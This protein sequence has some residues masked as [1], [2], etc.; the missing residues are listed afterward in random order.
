MHGQNPALHT[1]LCHVSKSSVT[2]SS[3]VTH[4]FSQPH[5]QPHRSCLPSTPPGPPRLLPPPAEPTGSSF[6]VA[7]AARQLG[8]REQLQWLSCRASAER[9]RCWE[10]PKPSNVTT[11]TSQASS[12]GIHHDLISTCGWPMVKAQSE[13]MAAADLVATY[14]ELSRGTSLR[15]DEYSHARCVCSC[16]C[17]CWSNTFGLF[18]DYVYANILLWMFYSSLKITIVALIRSYLS[19][20][21]PS[22]RKLDILFISCI[23]IL[24]SI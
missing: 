23:G 17:W 2:Y 14:G 5:C 11:A 9:A 8:L 19:T 6:S 7:A 20:L 12:S 18:H 24:L 13:R 15:A 4:P 22:F 21:M 1:I 3:T 10:D 16:A